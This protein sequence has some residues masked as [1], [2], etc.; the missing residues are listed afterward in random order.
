MDAR[1]RW[2]RR[3]ARLGTLG[4]FLFILAFRHA[5][6]SAL[7]PF[8]YVQLVW[9]MAVGWLVFGNFPDR[10]SLAGIAVIAGSGL[11][12][13]L[14]RA[15]PRGHR[16]AADGG[17]TAVAG[18]RAEGRRKAARCRIRAERVKIGPAA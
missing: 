18:P 17:L 13:A 5:P 6:A 10:W 12:L 4:H 2:S 11:L 3:S 8:T 16:G 15:A 14:A 1:R 7:T 9:A